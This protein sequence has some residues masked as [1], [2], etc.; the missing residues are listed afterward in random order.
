MWIAQFPRFLY[1]LV[2]VYMRTGYLSLGSAI[3][4]SLV[5][6][7]SASAQR[8]D[9]DIRIGGRGPVSGH[10]RIGTPRGRVEDRR[11]D[12]ND[13][14]RDDRYGRGGRSSRDDR[15]GRG[16]GRSRQIRIDIFG[17]RDRSWREGWYRQFQRQARVVIV[18]YDRRDDCYYDRYAPGLQ[19]IR[20]F[21]RDGHYYRMDD[22]GYDDRYD[23]RDN[24]GWPDGP[25]R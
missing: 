5:S 12:R 8:V 25:D 24:R 13:R 1:L 11:G 7:G 20:V 9:A 4:F 17:R 23:G 14:G 15:Y 22:Q 16:N 18:Y 2:E 6:A 10:V 21:E 19:E 3:L